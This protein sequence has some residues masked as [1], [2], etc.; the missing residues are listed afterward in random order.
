MSLKWFVAVDL[1]ILLCALADGIQGAERGLT[2]ACL[3]LVGV[4]LIL[5]MTGR[6]ALRRKVGLE[7]ADK[8]HYSGLDDGSVSPY[9]RTSY[10]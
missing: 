4:A 7:I 1:S 3:C 9:D 2:I 6:Y 8:R 5:R 10:K